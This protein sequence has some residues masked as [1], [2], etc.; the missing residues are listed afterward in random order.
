[1]TEVM[2]VIRD[3]IKFIRE[4]S[5][6]ELNKD[7]ASRVEAR[8]CSTYGGERLYL[9]KSPKLQTQQGI[10]ERQRAVQKAKASMSR[11][12]DIAAA[13]GISQRQARRI[14]NGK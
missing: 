1:M 14:L 13:A 8:A 5:G 12:R 6:I 7:I 11:T 3:L 2:D 9:P 4:E 10:S